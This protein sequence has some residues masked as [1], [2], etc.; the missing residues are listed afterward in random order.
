MANVVNVGYTPGTPEWW[1]HRLVY[2]L[3]DRQSRYDWLE[4][5]VE[6]NHPLPD[7]DER[8]IK[9]FKSMQRKARTNYIG[10]I[11]TT[12]VERMKVKDFL[13]NGEVSDELTDWWNE[14]NG[15]FQ[16]PVMLMTA[17]ALGNVYIKVVKGTPGPFSTGKPKFQAK[18]PRT[19]ITEEDPND[20]LVTRAALE[21][22]ADDATGTMYAI[23]TLPD[24]TY[25]FNG[26]NVIE[27][28]KLDRP[29]L[30]QRLTTFGGGGFNLVAQSDTPYGIVPIIRI[31]WIPS[32]KGISK[33]EAEDVIDVQDRINSTVLDRMKI[34]NSHAYPQR[35][36]KGVKVP[37]GREGQTK[38]PFDPGSDKLWAVE[39]DDAQFG[40]FGEADIRQILEAI[41]DDVAD[42]AAITKTP[43][44]YLMGKMANVSGSTLDQAEA[45]M[46]SKTRSR[47]TA[48]GSGYSRLAK[49]SLI[50]MDRPDLAQAH[51]E[52]CWYDPAYHSQAES[53]DA[54]LKHT[55]AGVPLVVA[56]NRFGNYSS[57]ELKQ[58][59][60][61]EEEQKALEAE[62][63]TQE[64][65]LKQ[66]ALTA[67]QNQAPPTQGG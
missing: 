23:L 15:D 48:V 22:W 8:Y 62:R 37:K 2:R 64:M 39:N 47:T 40:E 54:M 53:A 29:G 41:R 35:W 26:P 55:Q 46:I 13:I 44:H 6:G 60:A 45:G 11:T 34:S 25:Y 30:T 38:P 67:K 17:A 36:A 57:V 49:T 28:N 52:V 43:A 32:F 59:A 31:D 10:M 58:I 50:Y 27:C 66:Q 14:N 5:Y 61:Y 3:M 18:D 42:M 20:P 9:A 21:M 65:A 16:S 56:A 19:T 4:A 51:V 7:G 63:A 1:M 12:P 33:A 24:K